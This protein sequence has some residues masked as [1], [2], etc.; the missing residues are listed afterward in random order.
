MI[1]NYLRRFYAEIFGGLPMG[2]ALVAAA[3]LGIFCLIP[4]LDP[5]REEQSRVA[6]SKIAQRPEDRLVV[7]VERNESLGGLLTRHGLRALSARELLQK[8]R[9]FVDLQR[10]PKDQAISL[11]LDGQDRNV[12]AVEFV[13]RDHI[14]RASATIGGWSVERQELFHSMRFNVVRVNPGDNFSKSLAEAGISAQQIRQLR[15]IFSSQIEFSS[16]V[17][18]GDELKIVLPQKQYLDGNVVV[19]P[20]AAAR[21]AISGRSYEAFG[22]SGVDGALRY[23]DSEGQ[24]LPHSFLPAPLKYERISSTFNLARPDPVTGVTR[25]HQAIDYQAAVGT[26]VVA[27]GSGTVEFAGWREGYGLMIEIKHAGGYASAYCHLSRLAE[28]LVDGKRV[29]AGDEI[30]QVGRTG[31]AT[32]PHLHFEFSLDGQRIDFLS[33]KVTEP[34]SL[35]GVRLQEFRREQQQWRSIMSGTDEDPLARGEVR[36]WQ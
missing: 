19:G 9:Q 26:P 36:Q 24:S 28:G 14:V 20:L 16:G 3:F 8:V 6:S 32:G 11:I 35:T 1:Q 2:P 21:W 12:R 29:K 7:K 31:H 25:P 13:L 5:S 17:S 33:V 18:A 27:I 15:N 30:G 23:Y 34:D 4:S 22:F 10:L